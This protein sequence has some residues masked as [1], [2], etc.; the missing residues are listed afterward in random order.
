MHS[1]VELTPAPAL[2]RRLAARRVAAAKSV[3]VQVDRFEGQIGP[4][5]RRGHMVVRGLDVA[6]AQ[7]L[8]Q[9]MS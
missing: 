1:S 5:Q 8:L 9:F 6:E 2:V 7:R 4:R 3:V